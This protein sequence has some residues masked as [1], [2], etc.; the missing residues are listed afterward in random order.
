MQG[1]V[2]S[3][4]RSASRTAWSTLRRSTPGIEATCSRLLLPSIR[5]SGQIRSSVVSTFSR[6]MRRAHSAL[7]LRRGRTVRSRAGRRLRHPGER[8]RAVRSDVRIS[9]PLLFL[10]LELFLYQL[11][12]FPSPRLDLPQGDGSRLILRSKAARRG[13]V[14]NLNPRCGPR[15][16]QGQCQ[17]QSHVG[18]CDLVGAYR[19]RR[20][21]LDA[22]ARAV[23]AGD[24]AALDPQG[25]LPL[26]AGY[27]LR[28]RR[29][30]GIRRTSRWPGRR[31]RSISR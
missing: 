31:R 23:P 5:N 8:P 16:H 3:I 24:G 2:S 21:C 15:Q 11:A 29:G 9:S 7:R 12:R 17:R 4:A 30:R 28:G 14:R 27:R 13:H 25:S 6:T 20:E 10:R 22:P 26:G 19:V 18:G 1:M